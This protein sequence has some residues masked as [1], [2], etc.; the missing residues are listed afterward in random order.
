MTPRS[1]SG[2]VR[3]RGSAGRPASEPADVRRRRL[4]ERDGITTQHCFNGTSITAL[5]TESEPN[6]TPMPAGCDDMAP[7]APAGVRPAPTTRSGRAPPDRPSSR[8]TVENFIDF[9]TFP[10]APERDLSDAIAIAAGQTV[11]TQVGCNGCHV[12]TTFARPTRPPTAY[13]AGSRSTRSPT[14]WSMTWARWAT[15]RQRG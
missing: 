9:M 2:T 6:G 13:R 12:T 3:S 8:T 4:Q 10:G 7:P 11:F 1:A 14:S 15:H 5:L